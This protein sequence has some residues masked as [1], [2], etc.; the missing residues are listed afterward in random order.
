[1]LPSSPSTTHF[2]THIGCQVGE[3]GGAHQR[4]VTRLTISITL[5]SPSQPVTLSPHSEF[6]TLF[7]QTRIILSLNMPQI[8]E[9][10]EIIPF[11]G[12][13]CLSKSVI[14]LETRG[15]GDRLGSWGQA[16][17]RGEV[18]VIVQTIGDYFTKITPG[19]WVSPIH[20]LFSN[21][22][23]L[24]CVRSVSVSALIILV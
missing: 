6:G 20:L 8:L 5:A 2:L 18:M 23:L 9:V 3:A 1:M 13:S 7:I 21:A 24:I 22:F 12:I 19:M 10:K 4:S 14:N 15:G 17:E 11:P 16:G